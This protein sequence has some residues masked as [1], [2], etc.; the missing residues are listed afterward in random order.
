MGI[1]DFRRFMPGVT[2]ENGFI[3]VPASGPGTFSVPVQSDGAPQQ[4]PPPAE[5]EKYG[6]N[7]PN[8]K[9]PVLAGVGGMTT[10]SPMGTTAPVTPQT[11]TMPGTSGRSKEVVP[12]YGPGASQPSVTKAPTMPIEPAFNPDTRDAANATVAKTASPAV[13]SGNTWDE[14]MKMVK[15]GKLGPMLSAL[16]KSSGAGAAAPPIPGAIHF[17]EPRM[18]QAHIPQGAEAMMGDIR[19]KLAVFGP[20]PKKQRTD[21]PHDREQDTYD[22]RRLKR[23]M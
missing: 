20:K 13:K 11:L 22:F 10:L 15:D 16:A 12:A 4:E 7:N 2:P 19:K 8:G 9:P 6:P 21:D 1:L 23:G 18:A 5:P 14:Y 17:G 3:N